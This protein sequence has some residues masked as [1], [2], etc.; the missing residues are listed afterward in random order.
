MEYNDSVKKKSN[1]DIT[2]KSWERKPLKLYIYIKKK[3]R[4]CTR[5]EKRTWD[6]EGVSSERDDDI[7]SISSAICELRE[8][9]LCI[10]KIKNWLSISNISNSIDNWQGLL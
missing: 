2:N 5:E 1:P 8:D 9:L 6:C 4:I 7:V 10:Q 3:N